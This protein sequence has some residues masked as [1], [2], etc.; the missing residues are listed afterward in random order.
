MADINIERKRSS[1]LP[2]L[3]G[4]LLLA[5]V[6]FAAWTFLRNRDTGIDDDPAAETYEAPPAPAAT[7]PASGTTPGSPP[8]TGP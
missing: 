6:A 8:P 3:L 7:E 1:V 4:L 5:A 2:W